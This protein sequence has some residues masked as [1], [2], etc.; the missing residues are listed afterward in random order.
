MSE[1][2]TE[3]VVRYNSVICTRSNSSPVHWVTVTG[4]LRR[5][6]WHGSHVSITPTSTQPTND[7]HTYLAR[8]DLLVRLDL[9]VGEERRKAGG[10]LVDEHAERPPVNRVIVALHVTS[11]TTLRRRSDNSHT[12]KYTSW[13]QRANAG[14]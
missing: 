3:R 13:P 9:F 8:D 7:V 12:T 10:H 2:E 5:L 6:A 14:P 4:S 11:I 1:N